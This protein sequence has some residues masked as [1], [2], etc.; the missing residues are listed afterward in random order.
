MPGIKRPHLFP[1]FIVVQGPGLLAPAFAV[2]FV[3]R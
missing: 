2:Y 3:A 1:G